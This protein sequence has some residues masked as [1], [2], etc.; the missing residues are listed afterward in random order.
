[1]TQ[2]T[3]SRNVGVSEQKSK[4]SPQEANLA[5]LVVHDLFEKAIPYEIY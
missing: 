5:F 4:Y 3:P 1:M 2:E